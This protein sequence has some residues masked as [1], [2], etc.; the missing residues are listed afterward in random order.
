MWHTGHLLFV[1]ND[2]GFR[3]LV[4]GRSVQFDAAMFQRLQRAVPAAAAIID[5]RLQRQL[6]DIREYL[7]S[8][9]PTLSIF[10]AASI[11]PV[12]IFGNERTVAQVLASEGEGR[13]VTILVG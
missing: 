4:A 13:S 1:E 9:P 7:E 5:K 10:E 2:E 12:S 8:S 3:S 11:D 6:T